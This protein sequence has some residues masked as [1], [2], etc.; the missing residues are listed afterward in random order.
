MVGRIN[1]GCGVIT[2]T[3]MALDETGAGLK[4]MTGILKLELGGL[5]V[6]GPRLKLLQAVTNQLK[7][8]ADCFDRIW[9]PVWRLTRLMTIRRR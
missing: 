7:V 4:A 1:A 2:I 8:Q 5:R 6:E 9:R 3:R